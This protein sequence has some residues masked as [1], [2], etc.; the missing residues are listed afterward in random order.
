MI[1]RKLLQDLEAIK[2]QLDELQLA[3][4]SARVELAQATS[5]ASEERRV[6]KKVTDDTL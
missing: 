1:A 2:H 6:V 4:E 3:H 5:L